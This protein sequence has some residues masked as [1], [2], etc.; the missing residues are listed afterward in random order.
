MLDFCLSTSEASNKL[1]IFEHFF[2]RVPFDLFEKWR[3]T[4][5][6]R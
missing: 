1:P 4:S 5:P 3:I 6:L 2:G